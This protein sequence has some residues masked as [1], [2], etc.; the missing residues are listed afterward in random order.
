MLHLQEKYH[1]PIDTQGIPAVL[2][3]AEVDSNITHEGQLR[4]L[5][6]KG[7]YLVINGLGKLECSIESD[8]T[9]LQYSEY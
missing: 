5:I 4:I 8:K 1:I 7:I 9:A 6:S 2:K 3:Q